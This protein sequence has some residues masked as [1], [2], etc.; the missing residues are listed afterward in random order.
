MFDLLVEMVIPVEKIH[1][2]DRHA[3]NIHSIIYQS[4]RNHGCKYACNKLN[5]LLIHQPQ[6][7]N[8]YFP[9]NVGVKKKEVPTTTI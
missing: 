7:P 3:F 5:H 9:Q 6:I 8:V 1:T 2:E 4:G